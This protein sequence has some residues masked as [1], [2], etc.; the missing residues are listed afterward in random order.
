M[1]IGVVGL[2][3]MGFNLSLNLHRNF[4]QVLAYDINEQTRNNL[5]QKGVA[6]YNSL[7]EMTAAQTDRK[8]IWLMVPS[9]K[10]VDDT[11]AA[12]TETLKK[13]DII[14][15]GGNSHY[16]DSVRRFQALEGKG[17]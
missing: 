2:G 13:G 7:K 4:F 3:K 11:I 16:K 15:D 17:I 1:Q 5:A 9:G 14:I 8:I 12:L 10:I 6:T